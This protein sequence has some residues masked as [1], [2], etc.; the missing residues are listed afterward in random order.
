M[1]AQGKEIRAPRRERAACLGNEQT[2]GWR[3][4]SPEPSAPSP[5]QLPGH[6]GGRRGVGEAAA[7][8]AR[9]PPLPLPAGRCPGPAACPALAFEAPVHVKRENGPARPCPPAGA[10]A[11]CRG[12][13]ARH[14]PFGPAVSEAAAPG[15]DPPANPNG[16]APVLFS[17]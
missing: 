2:R 8:S 17:R 1:S 4:A 16:A 7:R 14:G 5:P 13:R 9:Q 3:V 10:R 11:R 6:G 12:C 15:A